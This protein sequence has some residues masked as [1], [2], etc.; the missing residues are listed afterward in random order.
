[1]L[2]SL[3]LELQRVLGNG[4]SFSKRASNGFTAEPPAQPL[5]P[6]FLTHGDCVM[7]QKDECT[8][9]TLKVFEVVNVMLYILENE[10]TMHF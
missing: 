1:M 5:H 10:L 4:S 6:L 7:K 8:D 2:T 3:A 9:L